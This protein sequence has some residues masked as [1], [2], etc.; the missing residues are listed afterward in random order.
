MFWTDWSFHSPKIERASLAGLDRIVLVNLQNSSQYWPNGIFIDYTEDRVYWIDA[1]IDA[2]DSCDLNGN[3]RRQVASPVHPIFNM[4][5]FDFTVYD[6]ILYW[7]D[8]NT[9]SIERLNWTTAAYIGGFGIL[10]SDRVFG[11]ALL[12]NSRQPAS[13]GNQL[14]KVNNGGCSHLCLLTP[15]GYQCACPHGLSLDSDGRKCVTG[16]KAGCSEPCLIYSATSEI[17]AIE[18]TSSRTVNFAANLSRAVAL[19]VHV[20][21]KTIYWSDIN[22]RIIQ[23]M[24]LTTGI[25]EDIITDNL[26]IIDGLAVEWE[27]GLI[28][29]A[30]YSNSRVEVASSDGNQ[31]KILFASQV[32][33]PRGIALY[34]KKGLMFW[35]DWSFHSPKIERASL[36]G[37]DRIVLVNL[38]NSSQYWPNGIFIDY[39]EDRVYWIDAWIDAIDSCDLNGNNRRQVASPVHPIFNMHPFDFTVYDDILYWSDWNTDSIERLNWTTAAYIGGFGILTSDRVFGVALLDNSR[40]PASAGNQLCKVNNGGCSHLCLLT[41]GGY[42]CACPHGLSLDSDGRKCVTGIKAGCSEPCLIYSATSEINAIELTS[43]RTVNFAA[44]LSRAVALDVHVKE[45]TIYWSDINQRIIQRMNLT[46]GIIEDIITDNLGII[47]G[48]AVEWESGLIYWADYSNSRVE[49]ASSDGNQRKILFASQVYNPRGI[50]LYPK[51]G[52]MFWTDWSFHSPKI[53]R[54]SL[55]GLDRIVLVNLQNS[56]QYWPNGIFIDYTEDRVYWIDA[57]IDAI[58]SCDLNGNNRRQVASPVH[59]IFNMHPFDFTVYDDILYWSDW[60]TD[61]IERLNW[62]TAAYIGG[63]G[64]L[65]SDRVFGVALLDNSRQPASAGNQLCKVNNGGCSH[66]CLLTPGGYQCACPHGLS[67]DSDG[68]KCVT[69]I[70]A[71]CSEPCLIYSATSEINAIELTSSRT[72]NFAANLSRAVALDVH[73]KE[74][75]IYWSDINQ[76]IIQRMNLTTGIIEDII[77]DNLG[78]IDGLAVEWESGLIYWADYSNSRVE[79]ASSDGNQR[80]ILFASQVYNPR[81]IALYPKKGLMFWTDW[82]FHSP[83]IE[84]ASLAGLDRIVLVNLQNSSQYWPNGI[85]IDYT[86]D[87]VYWIDAWIDAIDSCDLN[88]NNRRQVASPV[89]P[90]FNMHPFDFTVY[91]DIL[92]WSDWNT[93]SIERLNWTTAAYIGGFGILTSDRVFGVALL[94]NSR[95]PASAGNQLCKVNNGGCSHLCLLTPGGYQCACPHGLS[96]DSDGRKCVT[97]IK[98]GCSEPC[99]IYSATSEI[100]AIELTSSRTVNFAANLSRAVALDVHVKEKTI[101]WS[102]INQRIIQR[103]N[104]TTGIIED[105]ITDNLGIID[106]LAVEW[107]SGL[108][109]WADYSNSRVEVASSDGNQRKIL[110][111]SQVYNPRGIALYP[112]KGLMFWT[113]WSFHSPKIERASLAGL[114]RIVLVNLQNSSQYWPNGIFIDYTED[115]VYW[116]DA[117]IDAIDS[118]DLN[119]NNRRQVASPVHPIFNMHPFDFTVYDDILYWSDWN[120]DSI[121]RLNWTTAAYIGGFGILTSDRVFGVALLDNSRQPASAGNQ[122]CKVNNGGCS[123]LCLLTPGGYQCACPHGL[124][125]DSDGRKCVTGIKAGCSEPC[126]IYSATSEINAIEL[127]SSRT[128]NFAANLSRAVALDVHVK[129]KTIYWSDINQRII[130]RMNLTTG[131]IEDIITDNLGIIDGL[132]VEWESGLIYWADYSNSRVEVAS[133]D[134]NQRKILFASQ[135]YNPRGIAL[136]PKKGLMFWTDWSFHSPKI[137]RASLAGLDRIVLVNL[138]NSSQYWPNGIFI[139]YTEDRVY[140][141]DAW[142]D[143]IDSCDLNGNNR[144][145]V[146]SP[147]HPIFNM[148]PFDFTVYD[149]I[150]YW[151]DWNT[152]SIERLN[153][154]TAAYIGGFGIL[155]SD[156]VFGVALLD[157]SRQPASAGNQLCKVNNGGCSHLCLLTPGGYQCACPHGLSLDSERKKCVIGSIISSHAETTHTRT[158]LSKLKSPSKL[159]STSFVLFT[160]ASPTVPTATSLPDSTPSTSLLPFPTSS[161]PQTFLASRTTFALVPFPASPSMVVSSLKTNGK[162]NSPSIPTSVSIPTSPALSRLVA[163]TESLLKSPSSTKTLPVS[164]AT[165]LAVSPTVSIATSVPESRPSTSFESLPKSP[166]LLKPLASRTTLASVSFP[167]SPSMLASSL[168]SKER[169]TSPSIPTPVSIPTSPALSKLVSSTESLLKSPSS[170]TSLSLSKPKS[171]AMSKPVKFSVPFTTTPSLEASPTSSKDVMSSVKPTTTPTTKP[172]ACLPGTCKNGGTCALTSHTCVCPKYYTWHDCSIYIGDDI[173][174]MKLSLPGKDKWDE[175]KFKETLAKACLEYFCKDGVCR[176]KVKPERKK[177]SSEEPVS[178]TADDIVVTGVSFSKDNASVEVEFAVLFPQSNGKPPQKIAFDQVITMVEDTKN[179]IQKD[180]DSKIESILHIPVQTKKTLKTEP[181]K[182]EPPTVAI[183]AACVSVAAVGILIA[184]AVFCWRRSAKR[185]RNKQA[186]T[187]P[188]DNMFYNPAFVAEPIYDSIDPD[189]KEAMD[190]GAQDEIHYNRINSHYTPV[191]ES[192]SRYQ[193]LTS[194]GDDKEHEPEDVYTDVQDRSLKENFYAV[195]IDQPRN[196]LIGNAFTVETN[197]AFSSAE[198]LCLQRGT[199]EYTSLYHTVPS[200][201]EEEAADRVSPRHTEPLYQNV[202]AQSEC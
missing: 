113:D 30:D 149:D 89:H 183:I 175:L 8:W 10:T 97:G 172:F 165:S 184:F 147:V 90:I 125:L 65:T 41:P 161:S 74:K 47:D 105:I 177:R 6:D 83:K 44:N 122:L 119:G 130:Q 139:D 48:L 196:P 107:E 106:G 20:K 186:A 23:R 62:T 14:C 191:E 137:E 134:G 38:Q 197:S 151:S 51:K 164:W 86:E 50:A 81:G 4:H 84:R 116:I 192:A 152:D 45:K 16:I 64:I 136:Y 3:N 128:V 141:I 78:I 123:H 146:A 56:S 25:I 166:S 55:A 82:S 24:N 15:G 79:V 36:A 154:T 158:S 31:R 104:L 118:C 121:E 167:T 153:W 88:G 91:D 138:Q 198:Y 155:T 29:W 124:S 19:D 190:A 120:T 178:F 182:D 61:S 96:L 59:P 193:S 77:T 111:A 67:L 70:K 37:L 150:L 100:N 2:I 117:W 201:Q 142:I 157:N 87:R 9:D 103:M 93:D 34:P 135:V 85:F 185:R 68:R 52:L 60:N 7:S 26:G 148:H 160:P 163:S 42:Q 80:K 132:A 108:I 69:G 71:G 143:A 144:R 115:R 169:S 129:E 102:D 66:L 195:P 188:L 109:Y 168:K 140:W 54:A 145:Q 13:A 57:W 189:R 18:L 63:F 43:S 199:H 39:T 33:N 176:S 171:L 159:G 73:V 98:A 35:T 156:R 127:T 46:T 92:Y 187:L 180:L 49:V 173:V 12:D 22:Q 58:D 99:L 11:V 131:I 101:Y 76:R 53:E 40:Q 162:S 181:K 179:I 133:S 32:Y 5:P 75:T 170:T 114:D 174:K 27:S 112:K 95:Q 21:E 94:D 17:N 72:V 200:H 202:E 110:F 1:W 194:A 28:Y 126:L